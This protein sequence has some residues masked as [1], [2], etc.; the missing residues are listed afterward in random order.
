MFEQEESGDADPARLAEIYRRAPAGAM[1][2]AGIATGIV[3]ALWAAFYV[4]V[5]LPRGLLQ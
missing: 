4:A 1:A 5:F 3:F 2:I